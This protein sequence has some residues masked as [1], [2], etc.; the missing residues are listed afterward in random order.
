MSFTPTSPIAPFWGW[1]QFTPALPEFY[2]NVYSA[3]E[4]IKET[5][6]QLYK[7][8][9]Y[10]DMLGENINI[11]HVLIDELQEALHNIENID[12][13]DAKVQELQ[14]VAGHIEM[15]LLQLP[16]YD[17]FVTMASDVTNLK[18]FKAPY[19][20]QNSRPYFGVESQ[21]LTTLGD[22]RTQWVNPLTVSA[23]QAELY[24]N[25]WLNDHPE[26]VNEGYAAFDYMLIDESLPCTN[27]TFD[28]NTGATILTTKA[29]KFSSLPSNI[30]RFTC[31]SGYKFTVWAWGANNTFVGHL[32]SDGTFVTGTSYSF[33]NQYYIDASLGYKYAITLYRED[34]T[35]DISVAEG[36]HLRASHFTDDSLSLQN[37]AADAKTV[38]EL[39]T[40][41]YI[42]VAYELDSGAFDVVTG[43]NISTSKA[44][45]TPDYITENI[46]RC[47]CAESGY[48]FTVWAWSKEDN[49]FQ[50]HLQSDG[51]FATG[52]GGY[53][54]VQYYNFT[55]HDTYKYKVTL[56]KADNTQDIS[57][58]E[59]SALMFRSLTDS[60]FT[61]LGKAADSK[62][63]G[64]FIQAANI[65]ADYIDSD[66][67]PVFV[68]TSTTIFENDGADAIAGVDDGLLN[69]VSVIKI[70]DEMY[71]MYYEAC[72]ANESP[73]Y[74]HL[75]LCFAYS[76][77]G[78]TF[79]KGFPSGVTPPYQDGNVLLPAGST[80]GQCVVKVPDATNPY[81]ML[82]INGMH[83]D[84]VARIWKSADGINWTLI[85]NITAGYNDS[86]VSC[87][88][89]GNTLKIFLRTRN[90]YGRAIA[91][92]YTDLDGNPLLSNWNTE[93]SLELY[94][95]QLYVA[96]ASMIDDKRELLLPTVYNPLDSTETVRAFLLNGTFC[97]ELALD[98]DAIIDDNVKSIYFA[99]GLVPIGLKT[100]AFYE[101]RDA[102]HDHYSQGTTKSAIRRI[103]ITN[104]TFTNVVR[105]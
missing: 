3:E 54:F 6:K 72:G 69:T 33:V 39:V 49:V 83:A 22:G 29:L 89:R 82:S 75:K 8:C 81:R 63:V 17:E 90:Y 25:A 10:A 68:G 53:F 19:P 32:Q 13:L 24:V 35:Q 92:L 86:P 79:V 87:V 14:R 11:D 64:D 5:C 98:T 51:T 105:P 60:T 55:Q 36:T 37:K 1:T 101:T 93:I 15:I 12:E 20:T 9:K 52:S 27:N 100:Y 18:D 74:N 61:Q 38:G 4:R 46:L 78:E 30:M 16:S 95:S 104:N 88:V 56:Y 57:E 45:R 96:A 73:D 41:I 70:S 84:R 66:I 67:T 99:S 2:W 44:L 76:T 28:G 103:E 80:H 85:K 62:A 94:T 48:K 58:D 7:L 97:K 77:D 50:G 102:D 65:T 21:V 59:S 71:Y 43:Y 40:G 34:N 91:I 26:I 31:D 42:D 47:Y 23:E